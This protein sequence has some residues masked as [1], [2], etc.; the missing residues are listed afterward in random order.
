MKSLS[1]L[2]VPIHVLASPSFESSAI[3][4]TF[5][6]API[7]LTVPRRSY[8]P[9]P[10][11]GAQRLAFVGDVDAPELDGR[12]RT[13]RTPRSAEARPMPRR[14]DIGIGFIS[15]PMSSV[16]SDWVRRCAGN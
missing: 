8:P 11:S 12:V 15:F 14:M 16:A 1:K 5:H 13:R 2:S 10:T 3:L 9:N 4:G 7:S 6:E